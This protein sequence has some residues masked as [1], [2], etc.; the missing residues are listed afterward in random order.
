MKKNAL[1]LWLFFLL[2]VAVVLLIHAELKSQEATFLATE[3]TA[4][5]K[6]ALYQWSGCSELLKESSRSNP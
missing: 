5:A 6:E 2:F 4:V 3:R 1:T